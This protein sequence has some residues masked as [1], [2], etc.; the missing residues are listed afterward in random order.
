MGHAMRKCVFR[1]MQ[2]ANT[3]S[4][5]F[6]SI[7]S[8]TSSFRVILL[9]VLADSIYNILIF[10]C[11]K[12]VSSCKSKKFQ[13]I[14]VSLN[15]TFNELLTNDIVSFEQLGP[16]HYRLYEC[17]PKAGMILCAYAGWSESAHFAHA[18]RHLFA[19]RGPYNQC[20]V[21]CTVKLLM[22]DLS[23]II[24]TPKCLAK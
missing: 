6:Q 10:F 18:Q 16:D 11:W 4:P 23:P 14:C 17:R 2:T 1:H 20:C 13:H 21:F 9:T 24:C 15:V 12:N 22:S 7:V 19:C 5:E 3:Q 8:L